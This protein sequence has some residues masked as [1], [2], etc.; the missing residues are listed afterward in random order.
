[1]LG[2]VRL[3]DLHTAA[4]AVHVAEAANVHQD[5][6][7]EALPGV[8]GARDFIEAPAMPHA[9][10]DDLVRAGASGMASTTRRICR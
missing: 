7:A 10:F 1:M 6:E 3:H 9:Q 8:E 5:V 4:M 2:G